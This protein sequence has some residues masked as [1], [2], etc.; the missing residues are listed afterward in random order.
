ME[1]NVLRGEGG[2]EVV[3]VI[4]AIL[5]SNLHFVLVSPILLGRFLQCLGFTEYQQSSLTGLV[6]RRWEGGTEV[7][8]YSCWVAGEG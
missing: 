8:I 3:R 6:G 4:K 5:Q 7:S 1:S 2:D